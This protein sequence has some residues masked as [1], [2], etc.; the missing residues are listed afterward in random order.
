MRIL[1]ADDQLNIRSGLKLQFAQIPGLQVIGE[2]ADAAALLRMVAQTEPDLLFMDWELPGLPP[3]QLLRLLWYERPSLTIIAMS[4]RPEASPASRK[5]GVDL[6]LS[7]TDPP[8]FVLSIVRTLLN[9]GGFRNEFE[10][11][12]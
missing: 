11:E 5:A 2:A 6:F 9:K 10:S 1:L 8:D 4:S 3:Q 12:N 7:K